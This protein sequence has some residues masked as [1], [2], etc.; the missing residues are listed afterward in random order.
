MY[1]GNHALRKD[2]LCYISSKFN[3]I[4]IRDFDRKFLLCQ[5]K[6]EW[7]QMNRNRTSIGRLDLNIK[8]KRLQHLN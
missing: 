8:K 4:T 7:Q 2:I 6:Q 3:I 5:L 1:F